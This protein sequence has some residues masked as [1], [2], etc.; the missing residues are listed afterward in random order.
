MSTSL[1]P[2]VLP[3]LHETKGLRACGCP[4]ELFRPSSSNTLFDFNQHLL[5]Q[6]KKVGRY[7]RPNRMKCARAKSLRTTS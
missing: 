7:F 6:C 4:V 1:S 2:K 5:G 3:F